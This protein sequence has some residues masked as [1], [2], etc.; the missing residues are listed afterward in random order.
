MDRPYDQ[1][2]ARENGQGLTP[3]EQSQ[4]V[5][6][7]YVVPLAP[8]LSASSTRPLA[9]AHAACTSRHVRPGEW[10]ADS[11]TLPG[12][13]RAQW[14][15][16]WGKSPHVDWAISIRTCIA[17][18]SSAGPELEARGRCFLWGTNR[19]EVKPA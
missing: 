4:F 16:N 3:S 6:I 15:A 14:L 13:G 10:A 2:F 18:G 5:S 7:L 8:L 9:E 1:L 19:P 12:R 11:R 17:I